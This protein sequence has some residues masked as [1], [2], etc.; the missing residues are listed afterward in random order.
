MRC[1][2]ST[3]LNV[4]KPMC[5]KPINTENI[6]TASLFRLIEMYQPT[7]LIDEAD[8]F[9]KRDDGRDNEEMRGMLNAGH[10]R[11]GAIIRTVGEAF[12]PGAFR[13]FG[14][15]AFAWLVKRGTHVAQTLED[16]SITIE[17]RRRLPD[18]KIDRLRSTRTGHLRQLGRRA[19]RW[20][21]DHRL[22]LSDADPSLPK[23]L[24]DRAQDNWRPLVAIADAISVDLGQKAHGAALKIA[25]ENIGGEDDAG[26]MLLADVA[27]F[28]K[29]KMRGRLASNPLRVLSSQQVV[30]EAVSPQKSSKPR[31]GSSKPRP[32][33]KSRMSRLVGG[34][35]RMS[36]M[37]MSLEGKFSSSPI[38]QL[39]KCYNRYIIDLIG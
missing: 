2:K 17:L 11:G 10:G 15:V 32:R 20:V 31:H 22:S 12:G 33:R 28:F 18:E 21:A 38:L 16:L 5:S 1:G 35:P 13:V 30:D 29:L 6:T 25:E 23:Q 3:L 4:I 36:R 9:L 14:P 26:T 39:L 34:H 19:A 27:A 37:R 24:G 7:L 8:S